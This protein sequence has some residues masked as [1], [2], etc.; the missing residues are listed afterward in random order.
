M[1][2]DI[3]I[4]QNTT[5]ISVLL[6]PAFSNLGLANAVEPLRAANDL[7]GRQMYRWQY[8]GLDMGPI[9]S[10]SG[11]PV[12]PE[13]QLRD[14]S[15]DILIACPSYGYEALDTPDCRRAL[16][17][18]ARRFGRMAGVDTGAW[19][20]AAAG[21]LDG[22]KATCHWDEL[23]GF[24]ERFPEVDVTAARHVIDRDRL[25][26]GGATTTL[27][28][29]LALIAADHGTM[30]SHEVAG[31]FMLGEAGAHLPRAA[32]PRVRAAAALMQRH[33]EDPLSVDVLA[34]RLGLTRRA[35]EQAF[36]EGGG[37]APARLYRRIRLN[38]AR[39]LVL[40]TGHTIAEIAGRC[41]YGDPAAMTR[42]FKSEFGHPPRALRR[43]S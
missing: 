14:A 13:A 5:T 3:H 40:E 8:L 9:R 2:F 24:A 39:R 16:Q 23:A 18:A 36:R 29:M 17:A 15:G 30:L 34:D 42:A 26:S 38:E 28:L 25:S 1:Q 33:I 31:L 35:L 32:L 41:G 27:E 4:M 10:S 19:L 6:F 12:T 7:S 37:P 20:L 21:L 22:Y 11:L 43:P